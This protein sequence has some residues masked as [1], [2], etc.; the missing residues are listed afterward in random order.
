M[1]IRVLEEQN[2]AAAEHCLAHNCPDAAVNRAYYA[3]FQAGIAI[4]IWHGVTARGDTWG[5]DYVHSQVNEQLI[6]R[7]KVLASSYK[8]PLYRA[9]LARH[10]ADYKPDSVGTKIAKRITQRAQRF[11]EA[12]QGVLQ[13]A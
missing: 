7:R 2:L 13:H 3:M 10:R 8:D 6:K 9:M 1:D 12:I 5:H 4:L 11:I